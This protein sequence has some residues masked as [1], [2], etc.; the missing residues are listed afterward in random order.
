MRPELSAFANARGAVLSPEQ[1]SIAELRA[2]RLRGDEK[3]AIA[4]ALHIGFVRTE[5]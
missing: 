5:L 2:G 1:Q 3:N 4:D